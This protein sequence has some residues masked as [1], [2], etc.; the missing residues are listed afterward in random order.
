MRYTA[1][2]LSE[3]SIGYVIRLKCK[4]V[5][6]GHYQKTVPTACSGQNAEITV[7]QSTLFKREY[8]T[9]ELWQNKSINLK[10]K[11]GEFMSFGFSNIIIKLIKVF[12]PTSQ[13]I[14][15]LYFTGF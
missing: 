2:I 8:T 4:I 7:T 15:A 5:L 9:L 11:M 12:A 6:C 3:W 14:S 1:W 13:V 10:P